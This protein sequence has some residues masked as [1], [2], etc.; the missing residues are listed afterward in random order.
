MRLFSVSPG[1]LF[2]YLFMQLVTIFNPSNSEISIFLV[3]FATQFSQTCAAAGQLTRQLPLLFIESALNPPERKK[4]RTHSRKI[5]ACHE[6]SERLPGP[7]F[8]FQ[9]GFYIFVFSDRLRFVSRLSWW[10]GGDRHGPDAV[11]VGRDSTSSEKSADLKEKQIDPET[12]VRDN[13]ESRVMLNRVAICYTQTRSGKISHQLLD[14]SKVWRI[15]GFIYFGNRNF[16]I[17]YLLLMSYWLS[18]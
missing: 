4:L 18:I 10:P 12:R 8:L 1:H 5:S 13:E 17:A 11:S 15:Y 9:C 6:Q 14:F 7:T 3:P 16:C 2:L